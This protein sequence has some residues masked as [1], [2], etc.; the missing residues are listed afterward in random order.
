[1]NIFQNKSNTLRSFFIYADIVLIAIIIIFSSFSL[2]KANQII[3]KNQIKDNQEIM[4]KV[5]F[6]ITNEIEK[7][8]HYLNSE[9]IK[10]NYSSRYFT[11]TNNFFNYVYI[12]D[13][14]FAKQHFIYPENTIIQKEI[15]TELIN[16]RNFKTVQDVYIIP[17]K[18]IIDNKPTIS[19]FINNYKNYLIA[20]IN[21]NT[22]ANII[23]NTT[24]EN[25]CIIYCI[26]SLSKN[27][28]TKTKDI[29]YTYNASDINNRS[30]Q[31]NEIRYFYSI[32]PINDFN[33]SV[34]ILSKAT[35]Y[36]QY[37]IIILNNLIIL[38]AL[39]I[40]SII[41]RS[42]LISRFNYGPMEIL[43]KAIE[44]KKVEKISLNSNFYEW[45]V[46]ENIYNKFIENSKEFTNTLMKEIN[47]K[48]EARESLAIIK[49]YLDSILNS[50]PS[51][52]ISIDNKRKITS[53]NQSAKLLF[54]I[55]DTINANSK[56]ET[57]IPYLKKYLALILD[58][59]ENKKKLTL[60]K[61]TFLI[62]DELLYKEI[63]VIPLTIANNKGGVIII[64]DITKKVKFQEAILNADKMLNI[65]GLIAGIAHQINNPLS[66][67]IT[68]SQNI[69]RRL[70]NSLFYIGTK[71]FFDH[72]AQT[73]RFDI[74]LHPI[75][76]STFG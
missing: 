61:E 76:G 66:T 68:G 55:P 57:V 70:S 3:L 24:R 29:N 25:N 32:H 37:S 73:P 51:A 16:F 60:D 62:E 63:T 31:I 71:K 1:M 40:L 56:F 54:Q 36:S 59:I 2:Y 67:I 50:L 41:F 69:Q 46:I 39:I 28:I 17:H 75:I 13:L 22:I 34:V 14:T 10:H 52:I 33:I 64:D 58:S 53:F 35:L 26:D 18:S 30:L 65:G 38:L 8:I 48:E 21:P 15:G 20:E 49:E 74:H 6:V 42:I 19:L 44:S 43:I 12:S 4:D 11:V 9:N 7:Y 45:N 47:E 23:Q 27:I 5:S 72:L